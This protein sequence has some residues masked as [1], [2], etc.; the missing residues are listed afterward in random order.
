M[1]DDGRA[2]YKFFTIVI[3]RLKSYIHGAF[4]GTGL[5]VIISRWARGEVVT[6]KTWFGKWGLSGHI[7]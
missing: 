3:A 5:W 2:S 6:L 4:L 1:R 7:T